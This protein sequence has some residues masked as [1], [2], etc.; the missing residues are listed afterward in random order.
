[1]AADVKELKVQ[2]FDIGKKMLEIQNQYGELN[3]KLLDINKEIEKL[4]QGGK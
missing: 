4:E 1:M 3:K 2:A